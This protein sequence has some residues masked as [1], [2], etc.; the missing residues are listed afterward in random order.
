MLKYEEN[1]KNYND[2][3]QETKDIQDFLA[4]LHDDAKYSIV[5]QILRYMAT[6]RVFSSIINVK[7]L[8][9]VKDLAKRLNSWLEDEDLDLYS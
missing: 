8:N 1:L 6:E 5:K 3:K 2:W 4:E 9:E 7:K